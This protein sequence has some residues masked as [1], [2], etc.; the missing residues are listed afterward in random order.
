MW[1]F[2]EHGYEATSIDDLVTATGVGRGAIYTEFGGKRDLFLACLDHYQVAAVTP[3][4]DRVEA[5]RAN[6][7]E[8]QQFLK[9]R[10]GLAKQHGLPAIGCLVSNTVTE[11]AAHD[12][13]IARAT[14]AHFDRMTKGFANALA[15][16]ML[17]PATDKSVKKLA[18]FVT[19]SVQG[20]WA[21]ARSAK[22]IREIEERADTLMDV[23]KTMTASR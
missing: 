12:P 5:E 19:L 2:W 15:N 17:R 1:Q 22:S 7:D 20:L 4:F 16:E 6:L 18:A 23:V 14:R 8:I 10:I 3:G 21:F 13:E 9:A 11:L